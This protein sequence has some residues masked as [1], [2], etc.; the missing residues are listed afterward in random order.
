MTATARLDAAAFAEAPELQRIAA[1]VDEQG[2]VSVGGLWGSSQAL[3][4]AALSASSDDT[5]LAVTSTEP[6]A[7]AFADDLAAF[8]ADALLFPARAAAP[9]RHGSVDLDS[10]RARIQAAQR[11]TGPT[12]ARPRIVVA[13]LLAMLQPTPDPAELE[14]GLLVLAVGETLDAKH[15]LR[16]LVDAGYERQPL[17]EKPGEVSVRGDIFDVFPFAADLP[18][19]IELFDDEIESLRSFE[20][21]EQRSVEALEQTA[22]TL[23][24]DAGTV[25]E[26]SGV[27]PASLFSNRAVFV[28]VE[29][30]RIEDRA[31][32]LRIQ[33]APHQRALREL[34][35]AMGARRRV[36]LQSLPAGKLD[37]DTRSVQGLSGGIRQAPQLLREAT[38]DGTRALVLCQSPAEQKRFAAVLDEAG[39]VDAA[40]VQL[41]SVA[42]GFRLPSFA[43]LVINHRELAGVMGVRR[44]SPKKQMHKT[45]AL[46][47]FFELKPGD[48]VVH[49]VHGLAL[50]KGLERMRRGEGEE[51]H[52]HLLFAEDVSLF[53][54]ATRIDLVQR[55][56]GSG[57]AP[58]SRDKIGGQSFR[59]RRERVERALF[60]LAAELLEVQARRELNERPPWAFDAELARDL[61]DSFPFA[62]TEDQAQADA[63]IVTDLAS[64]HPMD[65]LLCG[66]VGFGKTEIAVRAAFRV[67]SAGGQVA[68]LVPTT[69]LAHQ[70]L[71][72]FR[73]RLA[74]FPVEVEGLSRTVTGAVEKDVLE[75]VASGAVDIVI[76]T[77]RILSKDVELPKRLGL[78]IVDE[79][80]RFGVV[81]KEHFKK[82][83]AGRSTCSTLT[84]R[85]RSPARSTCRCR[86]CATSRRSDRRSPPGRQDIATLLGYVEDEELIVSA[87]PCCASATAGA[88]SSSSTTACSRS[89]A[90]PSSSRSWCRTRR[91]PSATARWAAASSS[92]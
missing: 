44:I 88:R 9:G 53:V 16:R 24:A 85:R 76:G 43:L 31:Q 35:E 26:G 30:L 25:E 18:L 45:R 8:G 75:R 70:H 33:S 34:E 84:R 89:S 48:F 63:D 6:E 40:D 59:R 57:G 87:K 28:E 83:R 68:V 60:D 38:Q 77:H 10:V 61:V 73:E 22:L 86:A 69:V 80:Q 54:P 92:R 4:L 32:G 13:P 64:P 37:L 91:S 15:L 65:R 27:L 90:G 82:L 74:D 78:V 12:G 51:E 55:Y 39:G 66:D 36:A 49:A 7:E 47:S 79:E 5:W 1:A 29:P 62:D 81:H 21:A 52:L 72:V 42:K 17:V 71:L 3:V 11:V 46:Q 2:R 50:F 67:A 14:R 56:I 20:P 23:A 19:R 58:P 41:G